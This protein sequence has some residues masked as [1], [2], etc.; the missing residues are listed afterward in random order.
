[1]PRVILLLLFCA[2][3]PPR[4][5]AQSP[6][7]GRQIFVSRCASCHGTDGNGG[8]LG[9]G[10]VT[11][12]PVRTDAGLTSLFR[13]GLPTAGMPA[14]PTLRDQDI[15]EFSIP[16]VYSYEHTRAGSETS[17]L[18]GLFYYESTRAAW[19]VRLLW[20]IRFSGGDSDRLEELGS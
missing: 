18:F 14:F 6:E 9:P 1:M 19:A 11:R 5:W 13:Q 4:A 7:P 2:T 3:L 20:L 10:I 12:V 17:V 16:L 8:E 15:S